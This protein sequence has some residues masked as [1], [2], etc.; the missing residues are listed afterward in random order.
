[1][2]QPIAFTQLRWLASGEGGRQQPPAGPVY[3]ATA[4]F[5]DDRELFSVVLRLSG[6]G[7]DGE[8][9]TQGVELRLLAPDRLPDIVSRI[10]P[11]SRLFITEGPRVVAECTVL[12]VRAEE[13]ADTP[14]GHPAG[15]AS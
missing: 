2:L 15:F 6:K 3:A 5:T 7:S 4:R 10:I 11:G 12:Y 9:N 14:G 1:M 8:R 13:V